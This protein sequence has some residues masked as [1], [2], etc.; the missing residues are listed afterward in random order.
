MRS[1]PFLL[2]SLVVSFGFLASCSNQPYAKIPVGSYGGVVRIEWTE[3]DKFI[4]RQDESR[5]FYFKRASGEVI[6]PHTIYTDGGSIPQAFW[7][8]KNFSPWA[9]GPAYVIHDWMFDAHHCGFPEGKNYTVDSAADVLQE[10]LKTLMV[11]N[12]AVKQSKENV[13]LIGTAVRTPVAQ[14]LWNTGV[15]KLPPPEPTQTEKQALKTNSQELTL[16][17]INDFKPDA[18]QVPYSAHIDFTSN[19]GSLS[20]HHTPKKKKTIHV[21]TLDF[22]KLNAAIQ[23]H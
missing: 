10:A 21:E 22:D 13:F 12:P 3:P 19:L 5:P 8:V 17:N 7:G 18:K 20:E 9:Y 6:K 16:K 11:A 1:S 14:K 23:T 15:C 2:S 4:F